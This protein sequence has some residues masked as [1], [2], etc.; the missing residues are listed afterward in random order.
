MTAGE[1]TIAVVLARAGSRGL[2]GK[3]RLSLL[4]RAMVSYTLRRFS[5]FVTRVAVIRLSSSSCP[6]AKRASPRPSASAASYRSW[7]A[8]L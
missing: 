5:S 7:A 3:N 6:S 1:G 4:D 8:H 2:P